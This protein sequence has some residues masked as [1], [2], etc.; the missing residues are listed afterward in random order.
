MG[1]APSIAELPPEWEDILPN[2]TSEDVI[3][4]SRRK[5]RVVDQSVYLDDDLFDLDDD[6]HVP[7]ALAILRDHPHL[8]DIR[9]KL[10]PGK[11][12]EENY[13]A[14]LFGILHDG[15]IDIEDVVGAIE[16]DYETGDE[17]DESTEIGENQV[18]LPP[19]AQSPTGQPGKKGNRKKF[20]HS[21]IAKLGMSA[22]ISSLC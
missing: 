11:M 18:F 1:N 3:N 2:I 12:T 15:G 6:N 8:K 5:C 4:S 16:D 22:S 14:A 9:F 19:L 21:P 20:G 7:I 10:V 13:W 17:V